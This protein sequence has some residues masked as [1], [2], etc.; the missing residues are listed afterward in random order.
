M[1]APA[2]YRTRIRHVRRTPL[3]HAFTYRGLSWFVDLDDLPRLPV[4]L[5][6]FA[7][8]DGRDHFAGEPSLR[9][10]LD[11]VLAD[12]GV[13]PTGWRVTALLAPRAFG[14]V[15]NPLSLYWCHDDTGAVRCVVAE[16]HNTYGGRHP[17]VLF[18][19]ADGRV[20][21]EKVFYVSPFN[22]VEG[23]YTLQV[24]EPGTQ[25]AVSVTLHRDGHRPFVASMHGKRTPVTTV[26]VAGAVLRVPLAP[27]LV[28]ARIRIQGVVL[29]LRGLPVVPRRTVPSQQ[30]EASR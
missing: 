18:P 23:R 12:A 19:D 28:A 4:W 25:L 30:L 1:T 5:R 20:E 27:Q 29:W 8:F 22:P 10:G 3:R 14:Y 11:E 17:Y 24:P 26:R 16:V 21:T 2:L 7:R 15:F 9:A 6:P 13:D